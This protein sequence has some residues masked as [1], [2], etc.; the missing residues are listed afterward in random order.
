MWLSQ[1]LDD[2]WEYPGYYWSTAYPNA[3]LY[4]LAVYADDCD[5][6]IQH[7]N[8][9]S[10]AEIYDYSNVEC[11]E[12]L[13]NDFDDAIEAC[14]NS[15]QCDSMLLQIFYDNH[16]DNLEHW[17]DHVAYLYLSSASLEGDMLKITNWT[18]DDIDDTIA[19]TYVEKS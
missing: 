1:S 17:G 19:T 2:L 18:D 15:A 12:K 9:S 10:Y 14:E 11:V 6:V 7:W 13:D 3:D 8:T 5:F 16:E 4:W